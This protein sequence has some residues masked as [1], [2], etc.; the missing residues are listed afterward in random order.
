MGPF[1]LL[2]SP[3]AVVASLR[4]KDQARHA[5]LAGLSEMLLSLVGAS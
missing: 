2:K 5:L 1:E 3:N 4:L